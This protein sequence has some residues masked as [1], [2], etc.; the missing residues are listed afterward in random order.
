EGHDI[1]RKLLNQATH[2]GVYILK[3]RARTFS[4]PLGSHLQCPIMQHAAATPVALD[5]PKTG[6]SCSRGVYS[7]NSRPA[8][9]SVASVEG[10]FAHGTKSTANARLSPTF[11]GCFVAVVPR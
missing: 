10:R 8:V 9:L 1:R 3:R 11:C 7:Q 6:W 4:L 2:A 5:D